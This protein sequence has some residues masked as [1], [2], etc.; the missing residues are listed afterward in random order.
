MAEK[1][2]FVQ[3]VDLTSGAIE[4]VVNLAEIEAMSAEEKLAL[5]RNKTLFVVT[6]RLE[7]IVRVELKKSAIT[8]PMQFAS[9]STETPV[10]EPIKEITKDPLAAPK[11]KTKKK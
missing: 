1:Q 9:L 5:S 11:G 3:I 10:E 8:E 7:P 2:T 6:H 4:R